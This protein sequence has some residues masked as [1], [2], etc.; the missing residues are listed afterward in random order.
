MKKLFVL[1]I[2]INCIST[3]AQD[4]SKNVLQI[5]TTANLTDNDKKKFKTDF[6]QEFNKNRKLKKRFDVKITYFLS[7]V[8][9][10]AIEDIESIQ[11][12]I[13]EKFENEKEFIDA[14]NSKYID[15]QKDLCK[16]YY[17]SGNLD[18][19]KERFDNMKDV[20][21]WIKK[22]KKNNIFLIWN[23][24]YESYKY[25]SEF[26]KK[27]LERNNNKDKFKPKITK[28]TLAE[29]VL[30]P[31]D[32]GYEIEFENVDLFNYYS[33]KIFKN[34]TPTEYPE[35]Q[36]LIFDDCIK[37]YT[38]DSQELQDQKKDNSYALYEDNENKLIFWISTDFIATKCEKNQSGEIKPVDP[39]CDCKFN[40]LYEHQFEL[41]IQGC[42]VGIKNKD[43][44]FS[45]I[46]NFE[47]QCN[48]SKTNK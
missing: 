1:I 33:I 14:L 13:N 8:L 31:Y 16:I 12:M 20:F 32:S 29:N 26:I 44:P 47:F 19:G 18:L 40:C 43:I 37:K 42:V 30:R 2:L 36:V 10:T 25:S 5:I 21:R 28:P 45:I 39:T 9:P 17:S 3:N 24:G 48:K 22:N 35:K 41:V 23:N 7:K 11:G 6:L 4:D 46:E 38:K 15:E 34:P 27:E